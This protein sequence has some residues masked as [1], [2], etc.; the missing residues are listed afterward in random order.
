MDKAPESGSGDCEFKSRRVCI[1]LINLIHSI[2]QH[3]DD[4]IRLL[5]INYLILA[6]SIKCFEDYFYILEIC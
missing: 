4:F 6:S 5:D 3:P 2:T 1:F